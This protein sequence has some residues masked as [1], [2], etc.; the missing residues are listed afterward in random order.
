MCVLFVQQE[1]HCPPVGIYTEQYFGCEP[2]MWDLKG[3]LLKVKASS[4]IW[5]K[6][7]ATGVQY[8]GD[9]HVVNFPKCM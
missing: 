4:Q 8:V 9:N 2:A 1:K 7:R 3:C 6:W 5:V